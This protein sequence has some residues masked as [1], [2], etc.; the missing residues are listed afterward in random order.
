[1]LSRVAENLY[2]MARYVERA[3]NTARLISVNTN[4][5]LDLPKGIAPGWVPLVDIMGLND[6]FDNRYKEPGERQVLKFLMGD[7]KNSGSILSS[8]RSARENCRTVRDT[9]PREVWE[10]L[11]ELYL[12]SEE[13]LND[14]LGK[15][16]RHEYLKRIINGSQLFIG[17]VS[18]A[19]NRDE[20]FDFLRIG[21]NLERADMTTRIIDVRSADLLPDD[22]VDLRP[23]DTI[24]WVSVLQSLSGYQMYRRHLQTQVRRDAV[25]LFLFKDTRFPRAFRHCLDIIEESLGNLKNNREALLRLR[26]LV[27]KVD[28]TKVERLDQATLHGYIDDLQANVIELHKLIAE[29]YFPKAMQTQMQAAS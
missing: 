10:E 7:K 13:R 23:F 28:R 6:D 5:L 15:R 24:Q 12:Y 3:E 27:R 14:G 18:S 21:R 8:L 22:V 19:Q 20:A 17:I 11:N 16:G 1:M 4:L 2:W 26:A 25:L 29:A 9:L